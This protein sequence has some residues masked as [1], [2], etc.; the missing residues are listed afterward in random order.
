MP[1]SNT[2]TSALATSP[3]TL[4]RMVWKRKLSIVG[5]WALLGAASYFAVRSIPPL[6]KAEAMILVDSQKIPD[7]YVSST[8]NSE[9]GDRLNSLSGKILTSSGLKKVITDFDLY[10]EQRKNLT[11]EEI[12][13]TM[14]K[15]IDI[16]LEKSWS[17]S[18]PG[19]FHVGF[20][21][22]VPDTVAGVAN[23]IAGLF[24]DENL[25]ARETQAEGTS[26]F[27]VTQLQE[28][29]KKLDDL[30]LAVSK[31]KVQHSGGLPQ[32]EGSLVG[33]LTRLRQDLQANQDAMNRAQQNKVMLENTLALVEAVDTN[34]VS[35]V[36][37]STSQ[38]SGQ[39]GRSG[40]RTLVPEERRTSAM[41]EGQLRIML[42]RYNE[43]YPAVVELK[44]QIA[45]ARTAEDLEASREKLSEA[46]AAPSPG[47]PVD[48]AAMAA[49][50]KRNPAE[51][52]K[53]GRISAIRAQLT[54]SN[55]ELKSREAQEADLRREMSGFQERVNQL[56][57]R[58]QEMAGVTRDYES[59]KA[60]YRALL[61]KKLA[62]DMA[63]E[64]ERRQKAER[65]TVV[66]PARV[67]EKP[68]SPNR[69]LFYAGGALLSLGLG[70][71]LALAREFHTGALLGEWEIPEGVSILGRVPIIVQATGQ[72]GPRIHSDGHIAK[73]ATDQTNTA[74]SRWSAIA[75][76]VL[77]FW[78]A[79][80]HV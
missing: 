74:A 2:P 44:R 22:R 70:V 8:V 45:Q 42:N 38:P 6:Y 67:P 54:L 32:Q 10:A 1:S 20:R 13:E 24:V 71:G 37:D 48:S 34:A 76:P 68:F 63:T 4:A 47:A 36:G 61:D 58:E 26:E 62:A 31:Y 25:R 30:E 27:I 41:L 46:S 77:R 15:D 56:P 64:M 23:R 19:A 12:L 79:S 53:Q 5:A 72:D 18:R 17:G 43:S 80:R 73:S 55:N 7:R 51:F 11:E 57:V 9:V 14:R 52:Q 21:G 39:S 69:P 16:K 66:D 28:A 59:A 65:F 50:K 40:E 60:D 3:L 78:R 29:K 35:G 75:V 33:T 49:L